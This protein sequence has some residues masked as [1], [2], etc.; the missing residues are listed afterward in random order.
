[1]NVVIKNIESSLRDIECENIDCVFDVDH[2]SLLVQLLEMLDSYKI[3]NQEEMPETITDL[4]ESNQ[5]PH[6]KERLPFE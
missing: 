5:T 6:E 4:V 1:M 3:Y 2:L